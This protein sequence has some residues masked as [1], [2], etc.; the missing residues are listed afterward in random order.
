MA[1]RGAAEN[2]DRALLYGIPVRRLS[3]IV[4]MIAGGLAT[5]TYLLKAPFT[6]VALPMDPPFDALPAAIRWRA[7]PALFVR[8]GG[9]RS[10]QAHGVQIVFH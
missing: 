5:L 4:W 8:S 7:A 3:T 10:V 1:V 9:E 6:G 2:T